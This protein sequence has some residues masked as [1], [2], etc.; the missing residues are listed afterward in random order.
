MNANIICDTSVWLYLGTL[1]QANLLRQLYGAVYTTETVCWE[2]DNGRLNR[3]SILN[4][5][6]FPWVFVVQPEQIEITNL[7]ANRLGPGERSALAYARIHQLDL[8]GL[9]DHQAR[10]MAHYLGLRAIGT[11]GILLR[12]KQAGLLTA[13]HPFLTTLQ[14]EGFR[15]SQTLMDHILLKAGEM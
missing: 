13:V 10:E 7:P 9:D 8:V 1:G 4:P 2:L 14:Q 15:I 6:D 5:R 3:P 12:A 11:V